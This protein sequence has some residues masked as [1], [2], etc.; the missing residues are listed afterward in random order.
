M[1]A[2][3]VGMAALAT[4]VAVTSGEGTEVAD[5]AEDMDGAIKAVS[6][7]RHPPDSNQ[8][9]RLLHQQSPKKN[10]S[11]SAICRGDC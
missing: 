8:S 9:H 11:A 10:K 1:A 7:I 2:A 5:T 3:T 6:S 4:E